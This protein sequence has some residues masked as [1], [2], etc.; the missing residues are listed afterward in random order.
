MS[1]QE[2]VGTDPQHPLLLALRDLPP[3]R[4]GPA[5]RASARRGSSPSA[6]RTYPRPQARRAR[7]P[8][9]ARGGGRPSVLFGTACVVVAIGTLLASDVFA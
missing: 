8:E 3:A 5:L 9:A 4:R 6:P 1:K 2:L 7:S